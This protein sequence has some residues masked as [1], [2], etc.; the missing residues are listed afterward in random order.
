MVGIGKPRNLV[1]LLHKKTRKRWL[2]CSLSRNGAELRKMFDYH[3]RAIQ[4]LSKKKADEVFK[5]SHTGFLVRQVANNTFDYFLLSAGGND[6]VLKECKRNGGAP[7]GGFLRLLKKST[8]GTNPNDFIRAARVKEELNEMRVQLLELVRRCLEERKNTEM[9]IVIHNYSL[10]FPD[11][12]SFD[13]AGEC[14]EL[15]PWFRCAFDAIGLPK[16]SPIPRKIVDVLLRQW[17]EQLVWVKRQLR[18]DLR[19]DFII[20]DTYSSVALP[21]SKWSNELH[22]TEDGFERVFKEIWKVIK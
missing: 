14:F 1:K 11:G 8:G 6:I 20:V 15:G 13:E 2:L 19:D 5:D 22:P 9:R 18:A 4:G 12:R 10:P 3:P 16:S 7:E 17:S 21:Q